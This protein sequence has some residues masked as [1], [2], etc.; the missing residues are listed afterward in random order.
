M[1]YVWKE[2]QIVSPTSWIT[3]TGTISTKRKCNLEFKLDEFSTS[4][5]VEWNL[6]VDETKM[7]KESL[8]FYTMI[9]LYL[10]FELGLIINYEEKVDEWQDLK[11]PMTTSI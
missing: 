1:G 5:E 9:G 4:R 2:Y 6:H 8:G 7:S 10:L 3:G 11:M